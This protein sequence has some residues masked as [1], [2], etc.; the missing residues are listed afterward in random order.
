VTDLRQ[1]VFR[2]TQSQLQGS[3]NQELPAWGE[4]VRLTFWGVR[5]SAP[6]PGRQ[7]LRYGGNTPC[8]EL[9]VGSH[10]FILDAGTG[11]RELGRELHSEFQVPGLEA[12][13]LLSHYH[14][15][16]VQG[17]PF[18]EPLYF[19][20]NTF[21]LFGPRLGGNGRTGL[22]QILEALFAAPYFPV[23]TTA[24]KAA[25]SLGELDGNSQFT[26][27]PARIRTCALNHPQ[28][29]LAYRVEAGGVAIVYA[30]D[31]EPGQA[32]ADQALRALARDADLLI[33]DAQYRPEELGAQKQGWGHGSWES[34]AALARDA[35]VKHLMLF[36]HE[37]LRSDDEI[38][39]LLEQARRVFPQTSAAAEGTTVELSRR[40]I[41][42]RARANGFALDGLTVNG[43]DLQAHQ[44]TLAGR[45]AES[46]GRAA[47]T[48]TYQAIS[49]ASARSKR[50]YERISLQN[51]ESYGVL[52]NSA[53][54]TVSRVLD[55]SEGGVSFLLDEES[56]VPETLHARLHV[57]LMP[58]SELDLR[59]IYAK[60][61]GQGLLRVGCSF[62]G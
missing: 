57:P 22:S 44:S 36:H 40:D 43:R 39:A 23:S 24:L 35:G 33:S 12:C 26:L 27:G 51:T 50:R 2:R 34:A 9:R 6:A 49:L 15:D 25:Y 30:T 29:A 10:L 8:V 32:E 60:P 46:V 37:P 53:R 11:L 31:H 13:I 45:P 55:L 42:V 19:A 20:G 52:C 4:P 47:E 61:L 56:H 5:G 62:G 38:D 14:W 21:H 7:T 48:Q 3:R 17:L 59:R 16:H 1:A 54:A 28:G 41:R 18:F 58:E